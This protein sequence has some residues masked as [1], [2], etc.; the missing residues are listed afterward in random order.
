MR[1]FRPRNDPMKM[2]LLRF[3][4]F[5]FCVFGSFETL[6]GN[7]KQYTIRKIRQ[8]AEMLPLQKMPRKDTI[9]AV[10]SLIPNKD[11][12]FDFNS[13]GELEHLGVSLFSKE[14]KDMLDS[15]ICNFLERILL[16]LLLQGDREG[17]C[18]KLKEYRMQMYMDGQ[19]YVQKNLW[20]FSDWLKNMQMPVSFAFRHEEKRASAVWMFG[21]HSLQLDFPLYRELIEGTD[22][23]ES[24]MELYNRIQGISFMEIDCEDEVVNEK[25]LQKKN[26]VYV[27]PG[28][29]FKIKELSSDRYYMKRGNSIELIFHPDFPE[30]S[31]SNLFLSCTHGKNVTLQLKHRQYGR[32]IP[33]ISIPLVN[34][35]DFLKDDFI[36][37]CHTGYDKRGDLET[38]V[39]MNHRALNY[40]HLLRVRVDKEKLFQSNLVLKG[41][42][43]SNIPQHYIKTLLK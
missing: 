17:I 34:F 28:M 18:F 9:M 20:T 35:L 27:L 29:K 41:D 24:D 25:L 16:E 11:L 32:F 3:S 15:K 22:K 1:F 19:D 23:K 13:K 7:E 31:L 36:L 12:V 42:F 21:T 37:T 39:V 33:E 43:Y 30:Y 38:V 40:V 8:L 14:M 26:N 5:Y 6:S 10:P 4:I 2:L